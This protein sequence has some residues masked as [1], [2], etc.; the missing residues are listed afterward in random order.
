MPFVGRDCTLG[1]SAVAATLNR[2]F[3]TAIEKYSAIA[4]AVRDQ[5]KP[6][7]YVDLGRAYEKDENL[8]KAIESYAKATQLDPQS[9]AAFLR[10]GMLH[11]RRRQLA[12]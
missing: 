4:D 6:A 2:N 10:S 7:A 11:G 9:G 5:Q 8:D 1:A 12:E 3:K